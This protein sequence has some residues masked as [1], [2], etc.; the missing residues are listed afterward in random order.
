VKN[1]VT[2]LTGEVVG[3]RAFIAPELEEGGGNLDVTPA[4]DVYSLGKV[5]YFMLSG[6]RELP[7][8]RLDEPQF[9][10]VFQ[11]GERHRLVQL[12]LRRMISP[13]DQRIRTMD[14]VLQEI[15]K[16][17][18]WEQNARR[19]PISAAGLAGFDRLRENALE[20][21][22]I[23]HLNMSAREHEQATRESVIGTFRDWLNGELSAFVAA[24]TSDAILVEVRSAT[25]PSNGNFNVQ[26]NS[27]PLVGLLGIELTI[28]E[29]A[30]PLK[31]THVL[32]F[33]LC[34]HRKFMITIGG[35][36]PQPMPFRDL[37]FGVVT[38]YRQSLGHRP[39]NQ[40]SLMG[41]LRARKAFGGA[42]RPANPRRVMVRA[43]HLAS[44]SA[45]RVSQ[46]FDSHLSHYTEFKAS[47]WP[48]N[49][50]RIREWII[51][52]VDLFIEYINT[53]AN[54]VGL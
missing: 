31:R 47:E 23:S 11:G 27:D 4:V 8:E 37:A 16:I 38:V 21:R 42:V 33:W 7:R 13:L 51:E 34:E 22:R 48:A 19:L 32:Q 40:P 35:T 44:S 9:A 24:M 6:G 43:P 15:T 36:A 20:R 30:D 14:E 12:L 28:A 1:P 45:T 49:S 54:S 10:A 3:P 2:R 17:E 18:E 29:A 5:I 41:Y 39:P 53:G 50:E 46:S 25:Q 52:A 26:S